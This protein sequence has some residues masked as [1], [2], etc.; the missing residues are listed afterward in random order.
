MVFGTKTS[1][2]IVTKTILPVVEMSTACEFYRAT[3]FDVDEFGPD[4]AIVL[5]QG[6]ELLHLAKAAQLDPKQNAAAIYPAR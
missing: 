6:E 2:R 3:G 5:H 4:Y 1:N